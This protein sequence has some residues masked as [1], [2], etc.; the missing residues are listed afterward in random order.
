MIPHH[1]VKLAASYDVTPKFRIGD[2]VDIVGPQYYAVDASNQFW[3][4]PAYC[5]AD[6]DASCQL[7]RNI[8]LHAKV[9]GVFDDRYYTG[10]A[11]FDTASAPNFANG[12]APF[13]DPRS[14]SSAKP[15]A[16]YAGMRATF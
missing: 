2:D 16:I 6:L 11:F 12:G 5:V 14:L 13:A 8:Q 1:R 15:R 4:L 3:Q 9:D 7:N 10:S